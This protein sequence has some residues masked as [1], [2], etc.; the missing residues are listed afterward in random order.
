MSQAEG[1]HR[2]LLERA[3]EL[4]PEARDSLLRSVAG[5]NVDLLEALRTAASG[6]EDSLDDF[7][8][9]GGAMGGALF[10]RLEASQIETG[11]APPRTTGE[12]QLGPYRLFELLGT[13]GM[14]EVWRA[15]QSQP[16]RREVAVKI[17]KPDLGG[18]Q[19]AARFE[20]ERQALALMNHSSIARVFDGGSSE[21]GSPYFVMELVR[22]DPITDFCDHRRLGTE[23]RLRL[24]MDV[25]DGVQ[26]AHHK[27]IIHRD[28]KPSNIIVTLQGDRPLPKIID[29]GV[30]KALLQ[31]LVADATTT[32]LGSTVGTPA[33]MS[34]EQADPSVLDVD[35]RSDVYSLGVL[36][37]ELLVGV[38]PLEL[39]TGEGVISTSW[40]QSLKERQPKR[41][42][43][44]LTGLDSDLDE[45]ARKR[46]TDVK[47]LKR[48]LRGDLDWIV[49]KALEKERHRRYGSPSELAAD[50]RRH[51]ED[52]PVQASP[53]STTYRLSKFV[54]RHAV[55]VTAASVV[56][57]T[58]VGAVIST[59]IGLRRARLAEAHAQQE[60][61]TSERVS[62]FL[63]GMFD[64]ADPEQNL[65]AT[66]TAEDILRAG[67]AEIEGQLE[68]EPEVKA[69]L[70]TTMGR[71]YRSLGLLQESRPLLEQ[72]TALE[73]ENP[74]SSSASNTLIHLGR[75]LA[76]LAD[77][78]DAIDRLDQARRLARDAGDALEEANAL[79][80]LGML[81]WRTDRFE[82]AK[83]AIGEALSLVDAG[84][85]PLATADYLHNLGI[86]HAG[87]GD[88]ES[89][90]EL[91]QQSLDIEEA[92]LGPQHPK[93]ANLLDSIAITMENL[94]RGE[95][96]R[97]LLERSLQ[98]RIDVY[99]ED[100]PTTAFSLFN[101]G[102]NLRDAGELDRAR[103]LLE[104]ALAIREG[105]VGE[106]HPRTADVLESLAI[107]HAL[108]GDMGSARQAFERA[109]SIYEVALG[110]TNYET[111]ES[112]ANLARV[113]ISE[114][115]KQET[116][117]LLQRLLDAEWWDSFDPAA[118]SFFA[119]LKGDPDFDRLAAGFARGREHADR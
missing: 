115:E 1:K 61:A 40:Q 69:R 24:F 100:H 94:G 59:S 112:V 64:R 91:Y 74:G 7:L 75:T 8:A 30:A 81:H 23:E 54:R 37:Y 78:D 53:P 4:E 92:A 49:M 82:E 62:E 117:R 79:N 66:V 5:N 113:A 70:L 101:L 11:V 103:E 114:G 87:S 27:G 89:A 18:R 45:L 19:V 67:V 56:L 104:R 39:E 73:I 32:R 21:D 15:E 93:V 13:G 98:I 10:D 50:I 76:E 2:E 96:A 108:A 44:R 63:V 105:S 116:L 107:V 25:C 109:L 72:A 47:S 85:H 77:Y 6:D 31:P 110:P 38:R 33:Y 3:R 22:G 35:T 48:H 9:T 34:P 14:G 83:E 46:R 41:P 58:L 106:N 99:G 71:V 95:E 52:E 60:A 88:N 29:F 57:L 84:E 90:L 17:I 43:T 42:S 119:P 20:S 118:E 28:L 80:A 102:R 65:G 111:L 36:L 51:L 68:D 97:T 26:H 55:A 12:R 16:V 86:A